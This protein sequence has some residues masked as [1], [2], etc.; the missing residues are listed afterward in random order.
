MICPVCEG[1][2]WIARAYPRPANRSL[3]FWAPCP[4]C[5]GCGVVSCCDAAGSAQPEPQ[6]TENDRQDHG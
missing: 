1:R 2:R 5:G 3:S 4:E 6:G